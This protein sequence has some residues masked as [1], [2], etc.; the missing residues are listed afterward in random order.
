MI[1]LTRFSTSGFYYNK[2]LDEFLKYGGLPE[3]TQ[4][5]PFLKTEIAQSYFR[6]VVSR[7]IIERFNVRNTVALNT[8]L[9]MLLNSRS[10]T[11]TKLHN[12]LKSVGADTGKSTID[13]YLGYAGNVYFFNFVNCFSFKHTHSLKIARKVYCV[14]NAFN[15]AIAHKYTTDKGAIVELAVYHSLI[16]QCEAVYYW[17]SEQNSYECDFVFKT[18][19][20]VSELIQVCSDITETDTLQ[21][22]IR[23]LLHA[24]NELHCNNLLII[25]NNSTKE[26][27]F[28]WFGIKRT[29]KFIPLWKWLLRNATT[30]VTSYQSDE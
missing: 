24:S 1:D 16:T 10:F 3:I 30:N 2:H 28:E 26:E 15:T 18:N 22:E 6:T 7:D 29:I 11:I 23:A 17:K 27:T 14:D 9:K 13:E 8:L 12:N 25:N 5:D 21:R 4:S 20:S 19:N